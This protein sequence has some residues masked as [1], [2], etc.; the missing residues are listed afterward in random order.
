MHQESMLANAKACESKA[1]AE[2][3]Q[4]AEEVRRCQ[5]DVG[6]LKTDNMRLNDELRN[7]IE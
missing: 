2:A 1:L 5:E 4:L 3:D 7:Q 6:L